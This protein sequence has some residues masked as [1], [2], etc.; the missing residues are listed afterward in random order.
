MMVASEKSTVA[1]EAKSGTN[2]AA[3]S[4][5]NCRWPS[6]CSR[7]EKPELM[8]NRTIWL[9][10]RSAMVTESASSLN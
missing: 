1:A 8:P 4:G 2:A 6:R 3:G 7:I 9:A 10:S 5:G